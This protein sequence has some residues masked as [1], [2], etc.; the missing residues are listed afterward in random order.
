M[1]FCCFSSENKPE[2]A[3]RSIREMERVFWEGFDWSALSDRSKDK[4]I[5]RLSDAFE[6]F[7]RKYW[8]RETNL[9]ICESQVEVGIRHA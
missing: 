7:E 5:S 1:W 4:R 2:S 8:I 3:L 9:R 6:E